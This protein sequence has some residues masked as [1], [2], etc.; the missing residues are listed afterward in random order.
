MDERR[1][2][3]GA[4]RP[5]SWAGS[6]RTG[7]V[8]RRPTG[9]RLDANAWT[10]Y[11]EALATTSSWEVHYASTSTQSKVTLDETGDA[12]PARGRRRS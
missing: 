7:A 9:R 2:L 5:A 10:L 3:T 4:A 12:G 1:L 6:V 8:A 11:G